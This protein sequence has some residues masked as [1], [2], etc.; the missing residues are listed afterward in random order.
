MNQE[1]KL[2]A[3]SLEYKVN[4]GNR[5]RKAKPKQPI[6]Q[7]P[8][9]LPR[10]TRLL[11]LAHHLQA[12][13]DQGIVKDYADIARLSGLS[14]ARVTQIMNLMLLAPKIQ[15]ALLLSV[16]RRTAFTPHLDEHMVRMILKTFIWREQIKIWEKEKSSSR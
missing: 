9:K 6:K 14:R 15:E 8:T 16:T 3:L 13:L 4:F 10:I 11:A 5:K 1:H 2:Q 12:L 7:K